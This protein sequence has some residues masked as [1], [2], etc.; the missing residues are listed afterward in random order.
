MTLHRNK[1]Q[2]EHLRPFTPQVT[3]L[4][5]KLKVF[6]PKQYNTFFYGR[7]SN[8]TAMEENR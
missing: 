6:L 8:N 4:S 3:I 2:G 1:T 5:D 7:N